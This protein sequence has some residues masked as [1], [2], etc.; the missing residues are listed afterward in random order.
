[1]EAI[2]I[3]SKRI[4]GLEC[5]ECGT[6]YPQELTP[7]CKECWGPLKVKYNYE[8]IKNIFDKNKLKNRLFNHWRY[9]E[10]LPIEDSTKIVSLDDGGTP[11]LHCKNLGRELGLKKLYVKNDTI[12]PTLSFKDRP[13]SVGITKSLELGVTTVGCASTGNL[14]ASTAAHASKAGIQCYIFV[15][16]T[17]EYSKITQTAIHGANIIGV[18]GTYDDANQLGIRAAETFGWG[19]L[20]INLRPYYTEG[21]KTIAYETC[22]QLHWEPPDNIIIP[23]GS[24]AL[25]C[26]VYRALTELNTID[27]ID[28]NSTRISGAQPFGCSPIVT[29][30]NTNSEIVPIENP[31]TLA[32]SLAIGNPASGYEALDIIRST[33]GCASAPSDTEITDAIKILAKTEGIYAEPAGAIT[34][35][36]LI[37]LVKSGEI[38]KDES[39]VLLVTGNGFKAQQTITK[40]IPKI[41]IIEP[42]IDALRKLTTNKEETL[43][44][45]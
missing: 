4:I 32:K 26:S 2:K 37:K 21:S 35:A 15:P 18:K 1:M 40:L 44:Y 29:S 5:P 3:T 31:E 22:E 16:S 17:I 6:I 36:A 30:K 27:F 7:I 8:I 10:L 11:L 42:T 24:G 33:N 12:N 39:I 9:L 41:P 38:K 25:L 45:A 28:N 14:A 43:V 34:L 20:N 19:L 23:M 13:A